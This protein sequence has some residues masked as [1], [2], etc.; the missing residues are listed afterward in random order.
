MSGRNTTQSVHGMPTLRTI[1]SVHLQA[2][3]MHNLRGCLTVMQSISKQLYMVT[4]A[5]SIGRVM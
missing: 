4:C 5:Q 1:F 3:L 2:M